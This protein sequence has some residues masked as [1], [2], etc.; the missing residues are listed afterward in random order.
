MDDLEVL[1]RLTYGW[2]LVFAS[3]SQDAWRPLAERWL[4]RA[5]KD[6]VY[7]HELLDVLVGG[8]GSR[9][10]VLARLYAMTRGPELRP[11]VS[12]LLLEKIN[13]AQDVQFA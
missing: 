8:G 10:G 3:S 12:G 4:L 2:D 1:R 6:G 9:T 7:Q 5:A 11:A 13:V